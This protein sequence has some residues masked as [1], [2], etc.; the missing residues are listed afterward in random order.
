MKIRTDFVTNS[1]STSFIFKE[2]NLEQHKD[3]I[4]KTIKKMIDEDENNFWDENYIFEQFDQVCN[5]IKRIKDHDI[6]NLDE[7]YGWYPI[8][9]MDG[10]VFKLFWGEKNHD[11]KEFTPDQEEFFRQNLTDKDVDEMAVFIIQ[12]MLSYGFR[13]EDGH[14][15]IKNSVTAKQIEEYLIPFRDKPEE[16][17]ERRPTIEKWIRYCGYERTLDAML[18]YADVSYGEITEM[19]IEKKYGAKYLYFDEEETHYIIPEAIQKHTDSLVAYQ[20]H[21]G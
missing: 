13:D 16:M 14:R 1:S 4:A 17:T 2:D 18:K 5:N 6:W 11:E 10:E 9:G 19:L 15:E 7:L 3:D 8:P 20:T 12:D 21:M